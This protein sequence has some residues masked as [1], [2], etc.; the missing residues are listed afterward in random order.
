LKA[1]TL[2][3]SIVKFFIASKAIPKSGGK[4]NVIGRVMDS[5]RKGKTCQRV[6][7]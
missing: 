1:K 4:P 6:A 7:V 5:F 2:L 3:S